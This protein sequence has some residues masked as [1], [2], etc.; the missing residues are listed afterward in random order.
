MDR[1]PP[2]PERGGLPMT[3]APQCTSIV[4]NTLLMTETLREL[5]EEAIKDGLLLPDDLS[6][7]ID[8]SH[9][10]G[11]DLTPTEDRV[12]RIIH[13][14]TKKGVEGFVPAGVDEIYKNI[15][16]IGESDQIIEC[17]F[18][19]VEVFIGRIRKKLGETAIENIHVHE[20]Y[21]CGYRSRR[22]V[23]ELA[24]ESSVKTEPSVCP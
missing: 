17:D 1:L 19:T 23:I 4:Y 8:F 16:M 6:Y 12:Y 3:Y 11:Q 5:N 10:L 14:L 22:K 24:V 2:R 18:R 15:Y 9:K 20:D 7:R 13:E 21:H